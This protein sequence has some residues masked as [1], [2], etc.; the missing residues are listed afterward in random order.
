MG[1]AAVWLVLVTRAES[2][3]DDVDADGEVDESD[4]DG[5]DEGVDGELGCKVG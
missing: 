5:E 4:D 2:W 3:M 1:W